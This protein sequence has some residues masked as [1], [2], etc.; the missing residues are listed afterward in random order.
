MSEVP[1]HET[2][3]VDPAAM[4]PTTTASEATSDPIRPTETEALLAESRP[5]LASS[6]ETPGTTSESVTALPTAAA[7]T[8]SLTPTDAQPMTEGVLGYK[9][10]G[11]LK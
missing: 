9:A 5:E 7:A 6:T 10:P 2:L 3:A 11:L 1:V 4:D 8:D